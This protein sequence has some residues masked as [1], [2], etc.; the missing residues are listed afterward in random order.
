MCAFSPATF[1]LAISDR[2]VRLLVAEEANQ[3]IAYS[4]CAVTT[5]PPSVT[6]GRVI[7]LVNLYVYPAH[8]GQGIG[9]M[10]LQQ[11][12]QQA[13]FEGF[14]ALWLCVWQ[15]NRAA[16]DFYQRAGFIQV[17]QTQVFVDSVVFEDWVMEKRIETR[18]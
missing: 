15:E 11:S 12:L 17:G 9:A 10:L 16:L 4:K 14:A 6:L 8:Q 1:Q 2:A 3:L 5:P 13:I 18:I 7:E